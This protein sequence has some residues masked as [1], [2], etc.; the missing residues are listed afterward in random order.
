MRSHDTLSRDLAILLGPS[1]LPTHVCIPHIE[2][3]CTTICN[4][5]KTKSN[6]TWSW[7]SYFTSHLSANP[8]RSRD[9]PCKLSQQKISSSF[10]PTKAPKG[11]QYFKKT[12][13]LQQVFTQ[14]ATWQTLTFCNR[15][16]LNTKFKLC[17]KVNN[18][19]ICRAQGNFKWDMKTEEMLFNLI[20]YILQ[21]ECI[22]LYMNNK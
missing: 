5:P 21:R 4:Q 17:G 2:I 7:I 1:Q 8:S 22:N 20:S 16:S 3:I 18:Y 6:G 14:K 11:F 13:L 19:I 9:V 15:W 12:F 10:L